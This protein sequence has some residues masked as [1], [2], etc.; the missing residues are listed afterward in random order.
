MI[1][2]AGQTPEQLGIIA[3]E[4]H[5]ALDAQKGIASLEG[6]NRGEVVRQDLG[7]RIKVVKLNPQHELEKDIF[8][9]RGF[10]DEDFRAGLTAVLEYEFLNPDWHSGDYQKPFI[11]EPEVLYLNIA[12]TGKVMEGD[13][14]KDFVPYALQ[15]HHLDAIS[16]IGKLSAIPRRVIEVFGTFEEFVKHCKEMDYSKKYGQESREMQLMFRDGLFGGLSQFVAA[17]ELK[18]R[19]ELGKLDT[20]QHTLRDSLDDRDHFTKM[21]ETLSA[22]RQQETP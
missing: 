12:G 18:S 14:K 3:A 21:H 11:Q 8:R 6:F 1:T 20:S 19:G 15:P 13:Y 16:R 5:A 22:F 7:R 17:L 4:I 10:T 9:S 2:E